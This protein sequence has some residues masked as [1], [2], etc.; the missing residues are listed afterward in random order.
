[1]SGPQISFVRRVAISG[2]L[3]LALVPL[4][5]C[6]G[7]SGNEGGGA[8]TDD[9]GRHTVTFTNEQS[10]IRRIF[11]TSPNTGFVTL[12]RDSGPTMYVMLGDGRIA[13]FKQDETAGETVFAVGD[14]SITEADV[15]SD[16]QLEYVAKTS[17]GSTT[18]E[19][20]DLQGGGTQALS[21]EAW[22]ELEKDFEE[23]V[24]ALSNYLS[25][26]WVGETA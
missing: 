25:N 23:T 7:G 24:D 1:M 22:Q 16:G 26:S 20:E 3:L 4:A 8:N 10:D 11:L 6:G 19:R 17:E 15:D 18:Y 2:L 5:G 14:T 12:R 9:Y 13:H 21:L